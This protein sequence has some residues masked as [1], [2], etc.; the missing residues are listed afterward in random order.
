MTP[1]RRSDGA[2]GC[3]GPRSGAPGAGCSRGIEIAA[4]ADHRGGARGRRADERGR[5]RSHAGRPFGVPASVRRGTP[6][7]ARGSRAARRRVRRPLRRAAPGTETGRASRRCGR[8]VARIDRRH[9]PSRGRWEPRLR[10]ARRAGAARAGGARWPR[11]RGHVHRSGRRCPP[12]PVGG[13]RLRAAVRPRGSPEQPPGGDGLRCPVYCS[14]QRGGTRGDGAGRG[15]RAAG[16]QRARDRR[17][18]RATARGSALAARIRD[19]GLARV[20]TFSLE[21]VARSYESLFD[22][23]ARRP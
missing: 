6:P 8:H 21:R 7:H 4:H 16:K 13:R 22:E 20:Q 9:S 14:A 3:R 1:T 10:G 12:V 17:R 18:D 23:L 5:D 2:P 11:R 19:A 15:N